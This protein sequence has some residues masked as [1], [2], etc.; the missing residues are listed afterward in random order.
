MLKGTTKTPSVYG[1]NCET[2]QSWC[3]RTL[4]DMTHLFPWI[5]RFQKRGW[6]VTAQTFLDWNAKE[7]CN[8]RKRKQ[9]QDAGMKR[10]NESCC[11]CAGAS[12][13]LYFKHMCM[14]MSS[15]PVSV[16]THPQWQ[17]P[18]LASKPLFLIHNLSLTQYSCVWA[19]GRAQQVR[20][21]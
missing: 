13:S 2:A 4:S 20:H 3:I 21:F 10:A 9:T 14:S 7:G 19:W 6:T 8:V 1:S 18:E 12:S 5:L 15:H 16:N 17:S 11:S